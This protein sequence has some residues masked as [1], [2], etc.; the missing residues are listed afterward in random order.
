VIEKFSNIFKRGYH[1]IFPPKIYTA[2]VLKL[3]EKKK[4]KIIEVI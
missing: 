2:C 3:I 4:R 1:V